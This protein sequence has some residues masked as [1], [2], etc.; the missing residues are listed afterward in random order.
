MRFAPRDT[1]RHAS[2][3]AVE[4]LAATVD[5]VRSAWLL[6]PFTERLDTLD[7]NISDYRP[8]LQDAIEAIG[9]VPALLGA[10]GPRT[11]FVAFTT[12][13]ETRGLG[14]F[15]GNWIELTVDDGSIE[16]A[17][18]GRTGDLNRGG[19]SA[20]SVSGPQDWL[21][22]WGQYGFNDG[23]G[24][25]TGAVPWSNV[26]VSP[27]F[28]S[29]GQVIAEL[30]PQSGGTDVDGVFA[31]DPYAVQALLGFTG[32]VTV[33]GV[34]APISASNVID[35]L[36]VD[37]YELE[38]DDRIDVLE[39]VSQADDRPAARRRP[40]RSRRGRRCTRTDGRRGSD[41]GV[42]GRPG[43]PAVRRRHR[44]ERRSAA[45]RRR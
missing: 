9:R 26:T 13:A 16:I 35:F 11:Y 18:S 42:D 44:A 38:T 23:P 34:E 37:Q 7:E 4:T 15:M 41:H 24:G 6:G 8:R 2:T 20:R 32:P 40:P 31:L 19:T 3:T 29:T 28:S 21:D 45:A 43:R 10:D 39:E 17:E 25:T 12:P 33:E 36:L 30:Y 22:T 14:G 27:Q 5:D 1:V